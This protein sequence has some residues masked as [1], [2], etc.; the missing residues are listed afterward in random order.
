MKSTIG[1]HGKREKHRCEGESEDLI[2]SQS[3][4]DNGGHLKEMDPYLK[5]FNLDT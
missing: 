5:I 3:T 4:K 2:V 1:D